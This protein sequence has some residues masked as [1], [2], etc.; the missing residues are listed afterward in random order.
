MPDLQN[1]CCEM[2]GLPMKP[3]YGEGQELFGLL[4]SLLSLILSWYPQS[5]GPGSKEKP[6]SLPFMRRLSVS[7]WSIF[8]ISE[9]GPSLYAVIGDG[10]MGWQTVIFWSGL[11]WCWHLPLWSPCVSFSVW[12]TVARKNRPSLF[13]LVLRFRLS[14]PM[15]LMW[16]I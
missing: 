2:P 11:F 7:A 9:K 3:W 13:W 14:S 1:S 6:C 10:L 4:S 5:M 12:P 15:S 8:W 16:S